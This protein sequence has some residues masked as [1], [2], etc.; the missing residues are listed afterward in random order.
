MVIHITAGDGEKQTDTE[1]MGKW[2]RMHDANGNSNASGESY[3]AQVGT[4]ASAKSLKSPDKV[5]HKARYDDAEWQMSKA[6][7][8]RQFLRS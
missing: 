2:T 7:T 8:G 6:R 3:Q 4:M 1:S 5:S